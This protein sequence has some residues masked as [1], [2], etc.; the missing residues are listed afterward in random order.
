MVKTFRAWSYI[1]FDTADA[2][3][4]DGGLFLEKAPLSLRSAAIDLT[5][6]PGR[7]YPEP[8]TP[9]MLWNRLSRRHRTMRNMELAGHKGREP[10]SPSPSFRT[11][12]RV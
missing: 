12:T 3:D 9:L 10:E 4:R 8:V 6:K 7:V 5:W 1:W 11:C 2:S